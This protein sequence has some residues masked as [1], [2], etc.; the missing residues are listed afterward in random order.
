[1]CGISRSVS[2]RRNCTLPQK[3]TLGRQ[4]VDSNLNRGEFTTIHPDRNSLNLAYHNTGSTNNKYVSSTNGRNKAKFR[5]IDYFIYLYNFTDR[6]IKDIY[7]I[8]W[9]AEHKSNTAYGENLL[10][11]SICASHKFKS[12]L[13]WYSNWVH[14]YCSFV[15]RFCTKVEDDI[16]REKKSSTRGTG[17]TELIWKLLQKTKINYR[18]FCEKLRSW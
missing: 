16:V 2:K 18:Y 17:N 10:E 3:G 1:M 7:I 14:V 9:T 13:C 4:K 11:A 15:R 6:I 12:V 5:Q 8:S